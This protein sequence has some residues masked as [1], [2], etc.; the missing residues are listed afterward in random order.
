MPR[1]ADWPRGRG[2]DGEKVLGKLFIQCSPHSGLLRRGQLVVV[3]RPIEAP[4]RS[5][6]CSRAAGMLW[7]RPVTTP[8]ILGTGDLYISDTKAMNKKYVQS[9]GY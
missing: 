2:I 6:P 8:K 7:G 4:K 5:E 9:K 1:L 3:V